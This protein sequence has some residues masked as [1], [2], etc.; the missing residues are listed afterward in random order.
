MKLN[1]IEVRSI[2]EAIERL[3]GL[4]AKEKEFTPLTACLWLNRAILAPHYI[5]LNKKYEEL[6][7]KYMVM[8]DHGQVKMQ[9]PIV[10]LNNQDA[11]VP[12]KPTYKNDGD[13]Q[14]FAKENDDLALTELDVE[15]E[16]FARMK[17]IDCKLPQ[18]ANAF[19]ILKYLS[20]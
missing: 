15:L 13:E 7:K 3:I 19:Y 1:Y 14:K 4:H 17:L 5:N 12:S 9:T 16:M 8:D 20:I 2:H 11:K 10:S 18:D 6:V